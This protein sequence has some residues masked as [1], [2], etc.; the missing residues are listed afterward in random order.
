M[1]VLGHLEQFLS[2]QEQCFIRYPNTAKWVEK[3]G[4]A[5]FFLTHFNV[6]VYLMKH[7]FEC[8]I[9]LL[10]LIVKWG[11]NKGIKSPR[12]QNLLHGTDSLCVLVMNEFKV[13]MT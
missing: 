10:K 3:R 6:F 13:P 5:E 11:K 9:E 12:E 1:K 8:L 4:A 7:S 2:K